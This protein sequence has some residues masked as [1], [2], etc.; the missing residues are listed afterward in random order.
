MGVRL[1][2][3]KPFFVTDQRGALGIGTTVPGSVSTPQK[4]NGSYIAVAAGQEVTCAVSLRACRLAHQPALVTYS[5]IFGVCAPVCVRVRVC[6]VCGACVIFSGEGCV[7]LGLRCVPFLAA[8]SAQR[9]DC[10]F[11]VVV[12][13]R[14]AAQNGI[15]GD[16]ASSGNR[17]SPGQVAALTGQYV[18][19][20][21]GYTAAFA[22]GTGP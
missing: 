8:L 2:M 12:P 11:L 17:S 1:V 7:L 10:Q 9:V 14:L 13:V 15:L 3:T 20:A 19:V 6:G 21:A 16:G 22:V 5:L 4:V 18:A